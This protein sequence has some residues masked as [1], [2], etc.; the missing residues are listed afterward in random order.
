MKI[1]QT[2]TVMPASNQ[3]FE[4]NKTALNLRKE[5]AQIFHT[6]GAMLLFL[7]KRSWP[8]ILTGVAFLTKRVRDIEEYD[9]KKLS[10]VIKYIQSTHNLL[11]TLESNG[12]G[13]IKM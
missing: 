13:T 4:V 6:I 1:L 7:R 12:S 5:D 8:N 3:L 10:R 9:K 2:N 11:L